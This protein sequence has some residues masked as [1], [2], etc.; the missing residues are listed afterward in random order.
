MEEQGTVMANGVRLIPLDETHEPVDYVEREEFELLRKR[1]LNNGEVL[2][3]LR[4]YAPPNALKRARR[5]RLGI[6]VA[7]VVIAATGAWWIYPPVAL[8]L[9]GAWLLGD[10]LASRRT[11]KND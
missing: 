4:K 10:V 11:K 8:L 5:I 1:V 2:A 3:K 6:E 7:G 9:V